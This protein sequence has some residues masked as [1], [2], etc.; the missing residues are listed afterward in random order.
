[1][2]KKLLNYFQT[3][4]KAGCKRP[5]LVM[6]NLWLLSS[7]CVLRLDTCQSIIYCKENL[8]KKYFC[9]VVWFDIQL[10]RI[11]T[12]LRLYFPRKQKTTICRLR[13]QVESGLYEREVVIN[14][15]LANP[16]SEFITL[17][18]KIASTWKYRTPGLSFES[19]DYCNKNLK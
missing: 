14:H 5:V 12:F 2:D 19:K 7:V 15:C 13:Y 8:Q 4:K 9:N 11:Q 3:A 16:I 1:M 18:P 17:V 6:H 10:R